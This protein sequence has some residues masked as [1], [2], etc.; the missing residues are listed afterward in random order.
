MKVLFVIP[1]N[2]FAFFGYRGVSPTFPHLGVAYLI[3]MLQKEGCE[4]RL[5][6]DGSGKTQEDLFDLID[7][8]NPE[9]IGMTI[10]TLSRPFAYELIEKIK[11]KIEVPVVVGGAHVS[12]IKGAILQ[13][14]KA[15]FAIKYEG[16]Y[17]LIDLVNELKNSRPNFASIKNLIWSDNGRIVENTDRPLL[18]ELDSL[19]FPQFELYDIKVHPSHGEKI[20]PLITSRGCPFECNFCSVKLYMGR[21]FRKRSSQNVFEEIKYQYNKG[22]R[23]FDFNDDCFTL[24]KKRAEE[25]LGLIINSG[26]KIKFQFYNGLRADT[27]N[28]DI[29][30]KLKQ[31]GCFYIS[32][33]CESGN[34]DILK[35]IKKGVTLQQVRIAV[36][37]TRKAGIACSVNFII[38]H[39]DETYQT[40]MDSINFARSLPTNFVNFYNLV[41]YPGTEAYEWVGQHG[42]FLVDTGN[43]LEAISYADNAPIFE[44]PQLTKEQRQEIME[45]GFKIHERR[46]LKYRFGAILG[47]L[48]YLF[49]R[50]KKVKIWAAQFATMTKFGNRIAVVLS[51]ASYE[52][53]SSKKRALRDENT[54]FNSKT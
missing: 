18:T 44:T 10:Y 9:L 26:M 13:E 5:F 3:S 22:Y 37:W 20:I 33:G 21:G 36:E 29:L 34:E 17:P 6:D 31:A 27:V 52:R 48:I 1:K 41:P 43:Y 47:S 23:Q 4:V 2:K 19:P 39:K 24:D 11:N 16:E 32:Y 28:P 49:T 25:I 35:K 8:F 40:A 30:S 50:N 38:G 46:V 12:T 54:L 15:D 51:K 7:N 42:R 45:K 14:T 53:Y